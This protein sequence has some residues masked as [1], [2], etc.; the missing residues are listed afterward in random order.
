LSHLKERKEKNCLNCNAEVQGKFCH[1]CGQENIE[2][3]ESV[4]HLVTHFFQDIT[5]FDGKFFSTG[6]FLLW[7][8]GFLS[9]EYMM[10]RRASYLNP[11][12]MYV[13]TSA[14]F[15]LIFFNL[16]D[17]NDRVGTSINGKT[18]LEIEKMDSVSFSAFTKKLKPEGMNREGFKKY[19]DSMNSTRGIHFTTSKYKSKAEYDSLLKTGYKKHNW[20]ERKMIYKEIEMNEKYNN[21]Q[22]K[23]L[24]TFSNILIHSFPQMLFI[25]LP[26]FALILKL[27]YNR[28]KQFYYGH[29]AIF[30]IHL[31]V[32]FFLILLI[33]IGLA[34]LD[35]FTSA[36]I[37]DYLQIASI[38][39]ILFYE[40]K[41]LRVFYEQRRGKTILKFILL[42]L[43][44]VFVIVFLIVLFT[45]FSLLKV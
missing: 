16:F 13:F 20:L 45:F 33:T 12:R 1:I 2:P 39:Y 23:I 4:W 26:I 25:S 27:L 15:F 18:L 14:F 32:F 9:K 28:R 10:G 40:Y 5:H 30:A 21:D 38:V 36:S 24:K 43:A 19:L 7:K 35:K 42:N 31:Y 44:H 29:H 3:V 17:E 37:V 22:A 8:P 34:K 6:R 11:I 41:A